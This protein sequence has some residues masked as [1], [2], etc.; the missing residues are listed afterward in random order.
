M[1]YLETLKFEIGFHFRRPAFFLIALLFFV[2]GYVDVVSNA[3]YGL[4]F[5]YV[6]SPSRIFSTTIWYSA[7]SLLAVTAFVAETFVRDRQCQTEEL[8]F[9]TEINKRQYFGVR[10]L[11]A[12]LVAALAF[13]CYLPG[14]MLAPFTP[15]L[16][17]YS[18]GPFRGDAYAL[19]Y[20]CLTLPNL[21]IASG[22][23]FAI[24]AS[25]RSL[26]MSYAAAIFLLMLYFLSLL[27]VG[28]DQIDYENFAFWALLDP[29]GFHAYE[30]ST[31]GW[32]LFDRNT[33]LPQFDS[34]YVMN[35]A[36]WIVVTA[37]VWGI[38]YWASSLKLHT[39]GRRDANKPQTRSAPLR[40][41][42]T[43]VREHPSSGS[44]T[45]WLTQLWH[46]VNF[47][48]GYVLSGRAYRLLTI[49][50]IGSL[51]VSCISRRNYGYSNPSTDLLIHTANVYLE[52][53]LMA[54]IIVYA[55][56][57]AWRDRD[58]NT[59]GYIDATPISDFVPVVSKLV[60]LFA[61]VAINLS[62]AMVVIAGYQLANGYEPLELPLSAQMLFLEHGPRYFLTAVFA[63]FAHSVTRNKYVGMALTV[64]SLLVSIPFDTLG[65]YHNL[66]RW[67][68][69]ND[70]DYS[71]MN[72]YAGL[73]GG[74]LWFTLYWT[75]FGCLLTFVAFLRAP[76]GELTRLAGERCNSLNGSK[77]A[78]LGLILLGWI[79]TG[80]WIYYNTTILNE[81]QPPGK[82][83]TAAAVERRFKKYESL[84]MPVVTDTQLQIELYPERGFFECEG[85]YTLENR[86]DQPVSE[87]HLLTFIHLGIR[88]VEYPGATLRELDEETGYYIYDL[89]DPLMPGKSAELR[90]ETYTSPNVGFQN[91]VNSDDVYMVY[92]NDVVRNGT[93]LYSPFIL[94][95]VGYTKMV[96]HRKAWLRAKL[97]LPGLDKR[98]RKHDDPAGLAQ[99]LMMTHLP[100]S[101]FDVTVGTSEDQTPVTSGKLV[102]RWGEDGRNYARF[103]SEEMSRGRFTIFSGRYDV[104]TNSDFRVPI[105]VYHAP[106]HDGNVEFIAQQLGQILEFYETILGPY[107]YSN[108]RIAEFV[109]YDG[110]VFSDCGTLGIPEV[111]VWKAEDSVA[112]QQATMEWLSYLL[113]K[114][115]WQ[116]Q[117]IA[118]DVAGGMV[119]AEALSEYASQ[120][121]LEQCFSDTEYRDYRRNRMRKWFRSLSRSDYEEPPLVDVYNELDVARF[122]GGM[123]LYLIDDVVGRR[124]MLKQINAFLERNRLNRPPYATTTELRDALSEIR[125]EISE[126][127][128]RLFDQVSTF[129]IACNQATTV[130]TV[131]GGFETTA[132]INAYRIESRG[133]KQQNR[134][135]VELPVVIELQDGSGN[136]LLSERIRTDDQTT[137]SFVT[138]KLPN[139]IVV[140]P[141]FRF[142]SAFVNDNKCK[143]RAKSNRRDSENLSQ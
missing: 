51:I 87:L 64:V 97:N 16:P 9:S 47:E 98:M 6:N 139:T 136:L 2:F 1:R 102:R 82:E 117:L 140:D 81:Y 120:L 8:I 44:G 142:P 83:A 125:P 43:P 99:P 3:D 62:I 78:G 77:L 92:P 10:F 103:Q 96:E 88:N 80:C 32:T 108:V 24:A 124:P 133:M 39:A 61:V 110:M 114:S 131:N 26:T 141:E 123:T 93:N 46:C 101:S 106:R 116:D 35:R 135:R 112:S 17:A 119:I 40:S 41:L 126:A 33:K 138:D 85:K 105:E 107:P 137:V 11:A 79:G 121:Y 111:L 91:H 95:F 63:I 66:Y 52:Y 13:S 54:I 56:E 49:F 74:H 94:P 113:A 20:F 59:S 89:A 104:H 14:M 36:F 75:L 28:I 143:V 45:R 12:Y 19:S 132:T 30:Q 53:V 37:M 18:V 55:A 5:L 31:N 127:I 23:V 21:L 73:F 27:M 42:D 84:P 100:W 70:I 115:W 60:A 4:G 76:R 48:T 118:A 130:P 58:R 22:I 90:F 7:F 109:Y 129:Q 34:F 65:L 69:T 25:F 38:A 72:G 122:K 128:L 67:P 57:L 86:T 15:G 68:Q 134:H 71:P 50:G 29:F